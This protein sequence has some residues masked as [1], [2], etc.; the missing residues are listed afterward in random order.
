MAPQSTPEVFGEVI[1]ATGD[2][3]LRLYFVEVSLPQSYSNEKSFDFHSL[4]LYSKANTDWILKCAITRSAFQIDSNR[5]RWVSEIHSLDSHGEIATIKLGEE[6]P[7]DA[8]GTIHV[9]YSWRELDLL[10]NRE[11]RTIKIC[12]SPFDSLV[13][14]DGS[15]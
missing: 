4:V 3:R 13:R 15:K 6:G 10:E 5:S 7:P 12:K 11:V 8:S 1:N 9:T 14:P 2:F